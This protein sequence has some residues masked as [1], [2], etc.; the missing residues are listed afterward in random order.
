MQVVGMA[1]GIE[2]PL[3]VLMIFPELLT[4]VMVCSRGMMGRR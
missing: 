3:T 2:E 4:I 1:L